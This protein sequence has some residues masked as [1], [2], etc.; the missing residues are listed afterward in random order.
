M[1]IQHQGPFAQGLRFIFS[2]GT[3][4]ASVTLAMIA[5][6]AMFSGGRFPEMRWIS[7]HSALVPPREA[8]M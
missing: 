6:R 3:I 4:S 8:W 2:R 7:S 5:P 1:R